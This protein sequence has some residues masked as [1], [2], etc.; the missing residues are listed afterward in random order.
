MLGL[1]I[2]VFVFVCLMASIMAKVF[3]YTDDDE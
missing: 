1:I 3:D 2:I